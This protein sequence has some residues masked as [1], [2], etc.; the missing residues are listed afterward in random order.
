MGL[1]NVVAGGVRSRG[2]DSLAGMAHFLE[3]L[4]QVLDAFEAE[5]CAT[6]AAWVEFQSGGR[7]RHE[8][9]DVRP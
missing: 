3:Y 5:R 9:L 8:A 7:D 1:S 4:P 6:Q 2:V